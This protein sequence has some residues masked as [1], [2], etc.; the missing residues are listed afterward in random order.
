MYGFENSYN[1]IRE[2]INSRMDEIQAAVLRVKLNYLSD[3]IGR[4]RK[5]AELYQQNLLMMWYIL[6]L[7]MVFPMRI[8]C[9]W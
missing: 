3:Y 8:I 9:L 7:L 2:G 6:D 5:I 4:R 1:S